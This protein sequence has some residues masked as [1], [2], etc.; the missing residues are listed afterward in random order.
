MDD[1]LG[2]VQNANVIQIFLEGTMRVVKEW[3]QHTTKDFPNGPGKGVCLAM[4]CYYLIQAVKGEDFWPFFEQNSGVIY[5]QG[6]Q[7]VQPSAWFPIL[8]RSANLV[9]EK[10]VATHT[11]NLPEHMLQTDLAPYRLVVVESKVLQKAHGIAFYYLGTT[12][13]ILDVTAA[14]WEFESGQDCTDWLTRHLAAPYVTN[15]FFGAQ[16]S[17]NDAFPVATIYA[18]TSTGAPEALY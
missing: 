4:S 13:R 5:K 9:L 10:T 8:N 17:H 12:P 2:V 3:A 7:T 15:V 6:N 14:E 16:L 11:R 1:S 18:F